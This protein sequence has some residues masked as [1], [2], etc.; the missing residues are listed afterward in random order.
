[1]CKESK[2]SHGMEDPEKWHWQTTLFILLNNYS[3]ITDIMIT[4]FADLER[5]NKIQT[6]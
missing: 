6:Q 3:T 1:M 5:T 4:V 2:F